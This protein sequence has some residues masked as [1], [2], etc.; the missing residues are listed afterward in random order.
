MGLGLMV[1]VGPPIVATII[2]IVWKGSP[3]LA[4]YMWALML[5]L[6]L[7]LMVVYIVLMHVPLFN[8]LIHV[9]LFILHNFSS[10]SSTHW[11]FSFQNYLFIY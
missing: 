11:I 2:V 7:V 10:W 3:Y 5:S 4:L 9:S 8:K 6:S 1:V